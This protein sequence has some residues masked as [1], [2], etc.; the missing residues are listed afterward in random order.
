MSF[1][2]NIAD[3]DNGEIYNTVQISHPSKHEGDFE[4]EWYR[5]Q[6]ELMNKE[7]DQEGM[8]AACNSDNIL[9]EMEKNGWV[10]GVRGATKVYL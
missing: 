3:E 4:E 8:E 9:E 10:V 6:A 1:L 2:I 7:D 5:T